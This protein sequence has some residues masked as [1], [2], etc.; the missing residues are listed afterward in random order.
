MPPL[1]LS[2]QGAIVLGVFVGVV[3]TSIQSLGLTLQRKSHLLEEQRPIQ[4]PPYR[5]RR[6]QIGIGLFITSNILGSS[7]QIG[8]LPLVI[9]SPLQASG[10]VFNSICAS[11][12]L[13]EPFT[14]VSL[15][16]TVLVCI[17][18]A[19]IA[20]FG[21]LKEP[22]HNLDELVAL[23]YRKEFIGW[24]VGQFVIISILIIFTRVGGSPKRSISTGRWRLLRGATYGSISGILSA[25]SL[26][27][28]KS[29]VELLIRTVL[30]GE[31]QFTNWPA[32]V[33]VFAL[34]VA[35]L[36]QLYF[37]H[38]GLKL[39]STSVLY[40]LVFCIYNI[41]AISNGLIYYNQAGRLSTL[42]SW[43]I[44]LGVFILLSGVL[45]LSW[46]LE[47]SNQQFFEDGIHDASPNEESEEAQLLTESPE[48]PTEPSSWLTYLNIRS[49][50]ASERRKSPISAG[51]YGTVA[52]R[53]TMTETRE[54]LAELESE[55]SS[56]PTDPNGGGLPE[57]DEY[58]SLLGESAQSR[59]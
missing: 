57:P 23:F 13:G 32:W 47:Q 28:A 43:L 12:L 45:A 48:S 11:A 21:A 30:N 9:L 44:A 38:R 18:A 59:H 39:C 53:R 15:V 26:L 1:D 52:R 5:R 4:R 7:V 22:V 56:P 17:G 37:L 46:R 25:D 10:L 51:R 41:F 36:S 31:N 40:P 8:T 42:S 54:I 34:I 6:W 49:L 50:N 14:S 24:L 20:I 19:L 35:A 3:S 29:A 2:S 27:L 33:I 55:T 58:A 16:G